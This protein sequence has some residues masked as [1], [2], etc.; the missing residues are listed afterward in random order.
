[1]LCFLSFASC[2]GRQSGV[3][4]VLLSVVS[5]SYADDGL[6]LDAATQRIRSTSYALAAAQANL[7]AF[8]HQQQAF[9]QLARPVVNVDLRAIRYRSQVDVPLG[10]LKVAGENAAQQALSDVSTQLGLPSDVAESLNHQFSAALNGLLDRVPDSR[11]FS[12]AGEALKPSISAVLPLYTGGSIRAAQQIAQHQVTR[13]A[14][15]YAQTTDQQTLRVIEAYFGLQWHRHMQQLATENQR[16][17][18]LHLHNANALFQH[19]MISK[20]QVLQ[21]AVAANAAQRQLDQAESAI[22]SASLELSNIL[23]LDPLPP[24]STPLFVS[25]QVLAPVQTFVAAAYQDSPQLHTLDADRRIAAEGVQLANA[26]RL[27]TAYAFGQHSLN[28]HDWI[29]GIG[30]RY[31]LL[32]NTDRQKIVAAAQDRRNAADALDQQARQDL[33]LLIYR[34]HEDTQ[35]AQRAALGLDVNQAAALENLRVQTVA[36]KEGETTA[37]VLIDAQ[38]AWQQTQAERATA[39]YRYDMALATLRAASGQLSLFNGDVQH[40]DH[41]MT[42]P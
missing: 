40:A 23:Q 26:S 16:G 35:T 18:A 21:V 17:F 1:M 28:D 37:A 3:M 14:S 5:A 12:L 22:R 19:G 41:G 30:A 7:A 25:R 8:Q 13:A 11:R 42:S 31:T 32:A 38:T 20:A 27:P 24:L 29:I 39:A 33:T 36:F 15:D 34:A 10:D 2:H 6:S 4:A 9:T